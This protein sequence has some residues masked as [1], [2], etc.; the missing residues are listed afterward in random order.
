[1][2][3]RLKKRERVGDGLRRVA[4]AQLT[5]AARLLECP[6]PP[7]LDDAIHDARVKIKRVR[8][9]VHLVW[10]DMGD[11]ARH[12]DHALRA[13]AHGLAGSRDQA[14]L[15]ASLA[16]LRERFGAVDPDA[17]EAV[18]QVVGSPADGDAPTMGNLAAR[19]RS[20]SARAGEWVIAAEGAECIRAGLRASYHAARSA[21]RDA[22]GYGDP[23][24]RHAWRVQVRRLA[25]QL[26]LIRG[27]WPETIDPQVDALREITSALGRD[28][29]LSLL[30]RRLRTYTPQNG[31]RSAGLVAIARLAE[32]TASECVESARRQARRAFAEK[33]GAFIERV[34]V[35]W[36]AWR[37]D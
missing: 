32:R 14:S 29:D 9:I 30:A 1:M 2:G 36:R 3:Y 4:V 11:D 16:W 18:G 28:H 13:I 35:L 27:V 33:P 15:L 6:S 23:D 21:R 26:R 24:T 8:A 37:K 5:G 17:F 34:E 10:P 20:A 19:L 31:G 25:D 7:Q 22:L 12:E